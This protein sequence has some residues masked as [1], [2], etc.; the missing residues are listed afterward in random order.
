VLTRGRIY[1]GAL[2]AGVFHQFGTGSVTVSGTGAA[3]TGVPPV[4]PSNTYA[5]D[6][7]SVFGVNLAELRGM[8]DAIYTDP[9]EFPSPIPRDTL[10]VAETD[11]TFT[12]DRPLAGT[13]IVVVIGDV[14]VDPAS[15]STFSGLLYIQG[16]LVLREP[17]ELQGAIVVTGPVT[18]QGASDY[19]TITFDDGIVNRLRQT[20]GTYRQSSATV[21]PLHEE[22]Q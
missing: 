13:G 3:I 17:S 20:L 12:T 6:L 7:V 2:G 14:V 5:D 19:A 8:A 10:V 22:G 9:A 4:S 18:V 15:N 11:L 16:S 21:R 1:G